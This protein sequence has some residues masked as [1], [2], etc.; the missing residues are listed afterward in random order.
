MKM[1]LP[2]QNMSENNSS[3]GQKQVTHLQVHP[4]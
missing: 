4:V 3:E 2:D 1:K